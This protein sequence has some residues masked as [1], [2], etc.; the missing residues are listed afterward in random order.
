MKNAKHNPMICDYFPQKRSTEEMPL[1]VEHTDMPVLC[2]NAFIGLNRKYNAEKDK[3]T[4][5]CGLE[6]CVYTESELRRFIKN[7]REYFNLVDGGGES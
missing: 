7:A 5:H 6:K 3:I 4:R 1:C 2:E